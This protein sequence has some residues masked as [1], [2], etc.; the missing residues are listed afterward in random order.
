MITDADIKKMKMV[1]ATKEDLKVLDARMATKEDLKVLA[2]KEELKF[3]ATKKE[4]KS[5]DAKMDLGFIEIIN[6][7][8][9]TKEDI[10]S[11]LSKQIN[12]FRDEMRD[13]N[14]NNQSTLNNHESRIAHLEYA[15]KS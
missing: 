6:F 7:I 8:G 14:R 2:T 15:N 1:F 9:E 4:L 13:I 10:V 3:L 11:L 5:L 12:D